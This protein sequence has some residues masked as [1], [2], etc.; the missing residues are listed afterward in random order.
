MEAEYLVVGSGLTGSV[1]AHLLNKAKKNV[2][3]LERRS[4]IGGN[5]YSETHNSGIVFHKY[6]PHFFR[7][8]S[9]KIWDF[10][11]TFDTFYS[12]KHIVRTSMNGNLEPWP[13][14]K[15]FLERKYKL[16]W[17]NDFLKT[18][19][20]F[21]EAALSH[22]PYEIYE[23]YV[24]FY[25]QKQWGINPKFLTPDLAA[26][27]YIPEKETP[28]FSPHKYQALPKRGYTN[29]IKQMLKNIP[30]ITKLDFLKYPD[31]I[32]YK[33]LIFTGPID[34]FFNFKLGKLV[35]RAQKR[36]SIFLP[37]INRFQNFSVINFPERKPRYIRTIEW[38]RMMPQESIKK[39]KGTLVTYETPYS[40]EN[41]DQYEYPMQ[42]KKNRDLFNAYRKLS[43]KKNLFFAGRLGEYA[44][45]DMDI[46][47]EKAMEL[48]R[49]ILKK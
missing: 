33:N 45:Y 20:N 48:T 15:K 43:S 12:H 1:I 16:K 21:E 26:R 44:Y 10:V 25:T 46:A 39:I 3:V 13:L 19:S 11:N 47:I 31:K 34:E 27:L 18:P 2:L 7:T 22:M 4:E 30:T 29:L 9:K 32:S 5:I 6:G 42:D 14:N 49:A 28:Y 37:N 23:G 38:K 40:P 36:R 8:N 41:P 35:Y 17:H 24:K